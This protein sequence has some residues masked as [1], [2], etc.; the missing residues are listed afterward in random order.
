MVILAVAYP[1]DR[2]GPM[3]DIAR[4]DAAAARE[5]AALDLRSKFAKFAFMY[6]TVVWIPFAD[7]RH[8]VSSKTIVPSQSV[9]MHGFCRGS[10]TGLMELT[11]M[12]P[13]WPRAIYQGVLITA[14]SSTALG[15]TAF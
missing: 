9:L 15:Q 11:R 3:S 12:A 1:L 14:R 4:H 13:Q 6:F 5:C 2:I 7:P 10:P 8:S